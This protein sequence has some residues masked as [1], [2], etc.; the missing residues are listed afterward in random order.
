[1]KF[2]SK[3]FGKKQPMP[4]PESVVKTVPPKKPEPK[5]TESVYLTATVTFGMHPYRGADEDSSVFFVDENR[6]I[7]KPIIDSVGNIQNFPG[8]IKEDFWVKHVAPNYLKQQVRFRSDFE[9]R[10]NGW[11]F[12]WQL[13]PDGWYW[14]DEGGFGAENDSEVVLYTYLDLNGD[15][16][17]PFRIYRL[18]RRGYSLDR[19]LG[20]HASSQKRALEAIIDDEPPKYYPDDIFPQLLG[21]WTYHISEEFYQLS[22]KQETL[23][24]W[25]ESIL[26]HDLK[27]LAQAMLDSEKS[28]WQMM[29]RASNRVQASMTLFWLVTEDPVFKQMLDKFYEGKLHEPTVKRLREG[30]RI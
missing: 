5:R 20:H 17:G 19:F 24:Y 30:E 8:I 15:F 13:Q 23:A 6:G 11:I 4:E 16:T 25:K 2:L 18:D 9:K 29:G 28:L 22:D 26:S 12:L 7:R 1:M 21:G 14:A 3:L 27:T 10:D